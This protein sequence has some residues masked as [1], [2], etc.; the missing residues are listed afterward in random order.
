M[1]NT[2]TKNENTLYEQALDKCQNWWGKEK[3]TDLW[4]KKFYKNF[5]NANRQA[6]KVTQLIKKNMIQ[7]FFVLIQSL[8]INNLVSILWFSTGLI[9]KKNM[10]MEHMFLRFLTMVIFLFRGQ[11]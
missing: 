5:W 9:F 6:K 3:L 8:K 4:H 1:A 7:I 11:S 10:A 2:F